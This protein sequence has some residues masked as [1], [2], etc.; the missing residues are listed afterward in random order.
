MNLQK[1][2]EWSYTQKLWYEKYHSRIVLGPYSRYNKVK[3]PPL[4]FDFRERQV[5]TSKGI[6]TSIY[7]ND[8]SLLKDLASKYTKIH[9]IST[10]INKEHCEILND[11]SKDV[12]IRN[13]LYHNKYRIKMYISRNWTKQLTHEYW[14]MQS[15]KLIDWMDSTFNDT[16]YRNQI[17]TNTR[18][19]SMYFKNYVQIPFIY[20]NDEESIMMMKLM[21]GDE[22]RYYM[23]YA[24]TAQDFNPV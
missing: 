15:L 22:F 9:S 5:S 19:Y 11:S 7:T 14:N 6:L 12:E 17:G 13:K 16:R 24:Y 21:F 8:E 20:T 10:P 2:S 18:F 4:Y 23:T 1:H 3:F